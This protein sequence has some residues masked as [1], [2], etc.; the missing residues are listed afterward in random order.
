MDTTATAWQ[1]ICEIYRNPDR[2][3]ELADHP[4]LTAVGGL[5]YLEDLSH[6]ADP[7]RG[8]QAVLPEMR[9]LRAA[10]DMVERRWSEV[11]GY[12]LTPDGE[13][14][15]AYIQ[16]PTG[17]QITWSFPFKNKRERQMLQSMEQDVAGSF[18]GPLFVGRRDDDFIGTRDERIDAYLESTTG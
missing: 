14:K 7:E 4:A 15:R 16:L 17:Q 9:T 13:R 12:G 1:V 2:E 6:A 10:A 8:L 3:P 11:A 5:Q 18:V